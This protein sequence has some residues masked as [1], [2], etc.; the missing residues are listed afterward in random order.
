M[1]RVPDRKL[2]RI[3]QTDDVTRVSEIDGFAIPTEEAIRPRRLDR[4]IDA[5]VGDGHVLA[6]P[7]GANPHKRDAIPMPRIHVRLN[8]E[9]EA[10]E[11]LVGGV[12]DPSVADPWLGRRGELDQR[13]QE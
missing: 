10:G 7:A 2:S 13:A 11:S 5:A 12:D 1:Q 4:A 8:L 3:D 6:E 9:H